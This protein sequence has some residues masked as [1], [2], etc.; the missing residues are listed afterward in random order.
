M[1]KMEATE[2]EI[3]RHPDGSI[4]FG[5]YRARA[6]VLRRQALGDTSALK[7][8]G[9]VVLTIVS[10][11]AIFFLVAESAPPSVERTGVGV[12]NQDSANP[13]IGER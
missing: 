11:L 8:A 3:R 7:A 10:A 1:T 4:D 2:R 5:F 6:A 9:A 12:A 13:V